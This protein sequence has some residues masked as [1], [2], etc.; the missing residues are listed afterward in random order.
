MN[1]FT[2]KKLGEVIAFSRIGCELVDRSGEAFTEALQERGTNFVSDLK[3]L[4]Q[5]V[6]TYATDVT[7]AKAEKTTEK[8][9]TM[10]EQY[11]GD[12]WDNPVEILEWL[13]FFTGS[14]SAHWALVVGAAEGANN[15]DLMNTA[16]KGG[17]VYHDYLHDVIEALYKIGLAQGDEVDE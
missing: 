12:E 4:E 7:H 6:M 13:S 14:A 17:E 3:N 8:L 15:E 1:E 10:M 9:R 2:Q 11:V 5:S 16:E